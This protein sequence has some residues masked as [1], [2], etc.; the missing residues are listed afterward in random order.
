MTA[1]QDRRIAE[2]PPGCSDV[3]IVAHNSGRL[4]S[5]SVASAVAQAGASRVWVV[6]AESTDGSV[7]ALCIGG[8][9]QDDKLGSGHIAAQEEPFNLLA[10]PNSG[11]AAANNRG[12]EATRA[13][14]AL[15]LNPAAVLQ[16]GALEALEKT[17]HANPDA[18]IIG[19]LVL[20]ADGTVQAGSYGRFPS[21]PTQAGLHL[22]RI[23]QRLWG[24]NTVSLKAPDSTGAV[25]WV[26][27]AAM[28]VRRRAVAEVGS[29]DEGF[30][31]YY[32]DIDWCRRMRL[33]GWRV[34]LEPSAKVL[35]HRGGSQAPAATV[36]RAY[37][38]SFY[39]YCRKHGLWG[40]RTAA[41][42]GLMFRSLR[43]RTP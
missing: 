39:R 13:P 9:D 3:I 29:L 4:L 12:L 28:L 6:D 43:E 31:L 37:R 27:G 5:E 40:L 42:L 25:D 24:R 26:T 22:R 21:L 17:A 15:L 8:N 16:D 10:T 20:N 30:F 32:E 33:Q 19:A 34:L 2:R 7:D 14:F 41:R 1:K 23:L 11:F 18:G 36:A 35:H 38:E